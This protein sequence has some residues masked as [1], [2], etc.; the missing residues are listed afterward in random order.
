MDTNKGAGVGEESVV[1]ERGLEDTGR[2]LGVFS[3][4]EARDFKS[5]NL[6]SLRGGSSHVVRLLAVFCLCLSSAAA[7]SIICDAYSD[8][9]G[10][11]TCIITSNQAAC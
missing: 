3:V 2:S 9:D 5:S 10:S 1:C 4:N 6:V 8:D 7:Q 11:P